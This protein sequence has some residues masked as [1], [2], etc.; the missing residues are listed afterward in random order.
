MQATPMTKRKATTTQDKNTVSKQLFYYC[1]LLRC[2]T[3]MKNEQQFRFM[4]KTSK[5]FFVVLG[6]DRIG[7]K[8]LTFLEVA[9]LFG[10][11]C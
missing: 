4:L 11:C 6:V 10:N 3:L 9:D 1:L 5:D 8:A 2:P 7:L